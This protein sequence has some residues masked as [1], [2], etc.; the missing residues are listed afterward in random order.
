MEN[1]QTIAIIPA[2]GSGK[3]LKADIA[4]QYLLLDSLPVLVHTLKIFQAAIIIDEIILVVPEK[5]IGFVNAEFIEKH[6]LTKVKKIIAGGAERQ[7]SVK[8]GFAAIPGGCDV[9]VIHDGVRPFVTTEMIK[10]V[11]ASARAQQAASIGVMVKDT[12]KETQE[13]G[14]VVQTVP[15]RNLWL[16]Q[17]PQAFQYDVLKKAYDAALRDNYYGTDDASLVERIGVKVQMLAGSYENI[18]ITTPEDLIIAQALLKSKSG[19]NVQIRTGY[20]YDS[21]RFATDRKLVLGGVEIP[22]EYGLLGHSDADVLIHAVSDALLGAAGAGDIGRHFPDTDPAYKGI[23]SMLLL[24]RVKEIITAK[25]FSINNID[26]SIIMEK[27]KLT[28]YAAQIIANIAG[29]LDISA[30]DV[31]IKAKTNEGM[32]FVGRGEGAAVFAVATVTKKEENNE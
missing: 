26:V 8:N 2:G 12:V 3:R 7:D 1:M 31:N 10:R 16:T 15:R 29:V 23:S 25:K 19:G 28:P 22:F 9:I 20:G 14:L 18:K 5:D 13:D 24:E 4:K 11:V 6:A 30:A 32:G 27:P 21:H 17:T